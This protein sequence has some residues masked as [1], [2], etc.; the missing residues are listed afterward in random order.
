MS[1]SQNA[2]DYICPM[3]GRTDQLQVEVQ[4]MCD[5]HQDPDEE[6]FETTPARDTDWHFDA[7]S[8]MQCGHCMHGARSIY[9]QR[10]PEG[11][12]VRP[13][14]ALEGEIDTPA[15]A[16]GVV[17]GLED[18]RYTIVFENGLRREF[19]RNEVARWLYIVKKETV[20]SP[21]EATI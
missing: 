9:F 17:E 20:P 5:L 11:T 8:Y 16:R 13:T 2:Y 10:I 12:E 4:V 19:T 3:C 18:D 15:W 7:E 1:S 14:I 21:E 6:N